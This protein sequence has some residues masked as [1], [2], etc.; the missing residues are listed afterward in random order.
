MLIFFLGLEEA[1]TLADIDLHVTVPA[2]RG[3][4]VEEVTGIFD[5]VEV[6]VEEI[7]NFT[8]VTGAL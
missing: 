8:G 6:T 4:T 2:F 3:D 1:T 7:G 5:E